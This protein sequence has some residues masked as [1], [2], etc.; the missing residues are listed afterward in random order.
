MRRRTSNPS[1]APSYAEAASSTGD[2]AALRSLV[3]YLWPRDSFETKLR[4]VVALILLV[5]AKVANV[6]V[7]IFYKRAVDAL[8][9]GD[10]GALVTIPLGLIVAYGLA[11]VMSLV[12]AELRDAVFAN[13]AQRTIR[14][15]ALSVFQH[16]HALS[17]RFHLERQTGGLTRSLERGTR[18]IETLL[19]YALFSIVPTLVEITL[20]CVILWRMFDGWFALATFATVGS[21]IAYTFFVSEWRIQFRRAMNETDNKANTKAVDSLLNYET[22]K[23]FGNEGHEAR[24]YDQ[25]L[26]SYEQA[27]VKSQRSLSLLNIGQSAI[28]SLGLA[29]VMGM[30]ARGIVNGT[31]TLGDFVL[32]NTYLLQLYQPLNFFGVVYR[33]IK[34]ALI[35][36]ESMVTLLSVDREVADRPGAPPLAITGG[37]LRFDGVEFGY[38][39]RRPILKGVSFTVPA[40]RTVAIV[41]PSG[42]GKS[43]I[44][45]LLFRFYDVSGGGILID[46]QDIREVTQQS[47]RGAIGIVPQDTV[48]FNDTV[49][50]NI[51]YGRPGASP[52]EVEQAA[53]LAHIHNFIMALPDG[54]ETT[55]GERGLKLSGGEKQRVA[56]ARTILKNPAILLFDEATSALDT[57]TEREIQANLREVSRGR[58]TLVIAHRLST[59]IDADEILVMEA[60]RVIERG[61]HMELLSRGGAYAALWARQQESSQG[62]EPVPEV[63]APT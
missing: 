47:L 6:W 8:S 15:V 53:R 36:V 59:V 52:A 39:P 11:R 35:D 20:V 19:R 3:P 48:L 31:M 46:G 34:Q 40:G 42:A 23:Y 41:G 33:E 44:G 45:R 18:A 28:I 37:E 17:L 2:M 14:K 26:A 61:R 51:A 9:P 62:P 25:A 24:R 58:T 7:P 10:A 30:A 1:P 38:D 12:F 54:Y 13:V 21:Y 56:I 22:V 50:Y 57:H 16:L 49:Y 60:G 55:V 5:G 27:A 63:L 32:V 4:V 29:V 43:T